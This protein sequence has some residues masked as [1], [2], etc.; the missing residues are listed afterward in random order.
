MMI[1][2]EE[3][4]G[5]DFILLAAMPITHDQNVNKAASALPYTGMSVNTWIQYMD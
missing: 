5:K 4:E 1:N 2:E 3:E